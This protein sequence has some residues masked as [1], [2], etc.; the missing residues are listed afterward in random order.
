M[1]LLYVLCKAVPSSAVVP[2]STKRFCQ[3]TWRSKGS[4]ACV[5]VCVCVCV[6][7]QTELCRLITAK[8][9]ISSY[10]AEVVMFVYVIMLHHEMKH[11]F[12]LDDVKERPF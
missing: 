8:R 11:N 9:D 1:N 6:Q 3:I 4:T 10:F 7:H 2:Y 5:C 12:C